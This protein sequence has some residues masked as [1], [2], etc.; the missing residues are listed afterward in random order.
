MQNLR[1]LR[2]PTPFLS[3]AIPLIGVVGAL[4]VKPPYISEPADAYLRAGAAVAFAALGSERLSHLKYP[5]EKSRHGR[6]QKHE[7]VGGHEERHL[8]EGYHFLR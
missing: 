6:E 5:A 1:A 2:L 3:S 8:V 4:Y 7:V